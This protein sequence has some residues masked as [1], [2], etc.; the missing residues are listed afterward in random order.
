MEAQ[1]HCLKIAGT[2]LHDIAGSERS[3]ITKAFGLRLILIGEPTNV[4]GNLDHSHRPF[5]SSTQL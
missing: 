2:T 3:Q 1:G 4:H 5:P